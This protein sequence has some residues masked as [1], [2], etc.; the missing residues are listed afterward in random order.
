M[1]AK[2]IVKSFYEKDLLKEESVFTTY[3]HP[4][5]TLDWNSS[6]GF[7]QRDYKGLVSLFE[8][9]STSFISLRAEISHL[10]EENDTVTVRYTYFARPIEQPEQEDVLAHFVTIWEL[11]DQKLYKG[12]QISQQADNTLETLKSFLLK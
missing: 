11:K 12:Y 6:F 3:L 5:V 10:L 9:M 8:E 4:E 1:S 2:E 7:N